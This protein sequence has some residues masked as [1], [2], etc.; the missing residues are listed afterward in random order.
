[1]TA[2]TAP[3]IEV[4][5]L[6]TV[7]ANSE[8][9]H[10]FSATVYVDGQRLCRARNAGHG[11]DDI[12]EPMSGDTR[13]AMMDRVKAVGEQLPDVPN[14][15]NLT[16]LSKFEIAVGEAVNDALVARKVKRDMQ[17]KVLLID[18]GALYE[19]P[20]KPEPALIERV[21]KQ[22]PGATIVNDLNLDEAVRQV[23][24]VSG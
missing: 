22:Y 6:R 8:E 3:K 9:T 7:L 16:W 4:R 21:R 23:R 5:N 13:D 11:G 17:R 12:Y 2:A 20:K 15:P 24:A 19:V 1:M 10:C 14:L 18:E